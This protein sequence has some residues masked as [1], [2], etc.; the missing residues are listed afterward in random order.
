MNGLLG[1]LVITSVPRGLD[2]GA[3]IQPVSRTAGL[4]PAVSRRLVQLAAYPHPFSSGDP[5]NPRIVFHRIETAGA[6]TVHVLGSI[7]DAGASETGRSNLLAEF[8][9]IDHADVGR[10][11][12]GPAF[13][14]KRFGWLDRWRDDPREVAYDQE[15]P[16]PCD[17]PDEPGVDGRCAD[18]RLWHRA[19][20][21]AGWAGELA[22]AF[23]DGR[24]AVIDTDGRHDVL[25]LIVEAARLIP[26]RDRWRIT[27]NT[28]ELE[29]F[30]AAWRGRPIDL[31]FVGPVP[32]PRD[33][34]LV[35]EDITRNRERAPDHAFSRFA[36][37]EASA[38]WRTSQTTPEVTPTSLG[39]QPGASSDD[40][41]L[42]PMTTASSSADLAQNTGAG[43]DGS[44]RA[45]LARIR[46][47]RHLETRHL[48]RPSAAAPPP[49]D[50]SSERR[51]L[52][53]IVAGAALTALAVGA[54]VPWYLATLRVPAQTALA[55]PARLLPTAA[56]FQ[57]R[58]AAEEKRREQEEAD[59]ESE[60]TRQ[61][62]AELDARL[63][64]A[65][66]KQREKDQ[67]EKRQSEAE[68]RQAEERATQ[69]EKQ[70]AAWRELALDGVD[71]K[72]LDSAI[73][74]DGR[75]RSTDI[76]LCAFDVEH[77]ITPQLSFA[78]VPGP[79][80]SPLRVEAERDPRRTDTARD[81]TWVVTTDVLQ[82]LSGRRRSRV[83]CRLVA[84]DGR[85]LLRPPRTPDQPL[86]TEDLAFTTLQNSL[87]RVAA[88]DPA[89]E[90]AP[91]TIRRTIG[92]ATPIPAHPL[93]LDPLTGRREGDFD[94]TLARR[95]KNIDP[96]SLRWDFHLSHPGWPQSKHIRYPD[97]TLTLVLPADG[98]PLA[99]T[100]VNEKGQI[101][102][103][104]GHLR[105]EAVVTFF[106]ENAEL[107]ID[108]TLK[109]LEDIPLLKNVI[110]LAFFNRMKT[111]NSRRDAITNA[112]TTALR[113]DAKQRA[114]FS[115]YESTD[116]ALGLLKKAEFH[117]RRH[118]QEFLRQCEI[119]QNRVK[120]G[121]QL[122]YNNNPRDP[123]WI[124]F[125]NT[126]LQNSTRQRLTARAIQ[127]FI[128]ASY[129][130]VI[131]DDVERSADALGDFLDAHG[132]PLTAHVGH[133]H[134]MAYDARRQEYELLLTP[135]RE[136]A[137]K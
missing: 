60:R 27:F 20:G 79:H 17:D 32:R 23:L 92:F 38:P 131:H 77:L 51:P 68:R 53:V 47:R 13:V 88:T 40:E 64:A 91:P 101:I 100:D 22:R 56:E 116:E 133:L 19:T 14:A 120:Q 73:E 62:N 129:E 30:P 128:E 136:T 39:S 31:P 69:R 59:A 84:K 66:R 9:V 63:S 41:S 12:A 94:P 6:R 43:D 85:L 125:V 5:R 52:R 26:V 103:R 134:G 126:T 114:Q 111:H 99:Y 58:K 93:T 65:E 3:G 132:V 37:G 96:A 135:A 74:S 29:P 81:T 57:D 105:I 127:E 55:D 130:K 76:D 95:I 49:G 42:W 107:T 10:L 54:G 118:W 113:D 72:S 90:A 102:H 11:P 16:L 1:R 50:R 115:Y 70:L 119:D 106:P 109:G 112:L 82:E 2:G 25:D 78:C 83:V 33:L 137:G 24:D 123:G 46:E 21:D 35:I 80:A 44:R 121:P 7:R 108:T 98:V 36:R 124:A 71:T 122:A 45:Q 34:R 97:T 75:I 18:C 86:S 48:P 15:P 117:S 110:T 28:C 61:A 67:A 8:L 104:K 87:L 4:P 89:S